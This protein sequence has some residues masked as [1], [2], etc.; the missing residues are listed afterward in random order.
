MLSLGSLLDS[1]RG[2]NSLRRVY[3]TSSAVVH[4]SSRV[5]VYP[6]A[7]LWDRRLPPSNFILCQ[8]LLAM[9]MWPSLNSNS[10]DCLWPRCSLLQLTVHSIS[11][12]ISPVMGHLG[13]I[14]ML[15]M[16][17]F[18]L[19]PLHYGS[20]PDC[21]NSNHTAH[22]WPVTA[23]TESNIYPNIITTGI[24]V[25]PYRFLSSSSATSLLW[26]IL[27]ALTSATRTSR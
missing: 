24:V 12:Y 14:S 5:N 4:A 8:M 7:N 19:Q 11:S 18:S 20:T 9:A 10:R 15:S 26:A 22:L 1:Q 13:A 16:G 23:R 2:P 25:S 27:P 21:D 3:S 17:H 6:H